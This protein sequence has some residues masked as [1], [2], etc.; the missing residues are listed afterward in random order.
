VNIMTSFNEA[1]VRV[2][3]SH[4]QLLEH[5]L[6]VV[7]S[8]ESIRESGSDSLEGSFKALLMGVFSIK[9]AWILQIADAKHCDSDK[10]MLEWPNHPELWSWIL[11]WLKTRI[12]LEIQS[13]RQ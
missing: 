4:V 6:P 12:E 10:V 5:M 9:P 8:F 3:Q 7:T 13:I 2:Q 1:V 11:D